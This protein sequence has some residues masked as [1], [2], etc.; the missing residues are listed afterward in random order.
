MAAARSSREPRAESPRSAGAD[1]WAQTRQPLVCLAFLAPL[2]AVYEVGVLW[3]GGP[4]PGS[5]RNG[6]DYWMRGWLHG[7][8]FTQSLLLPVLVVGGLLAWHLAGRYP[9]RVSLD[10]LAGM[11]AE[12][13]LFAFA[14]IVL[15][16]LQGIAF[17]KFGAETLLAAGHAFAPYESAG[18]VLAV[19]HPVAARAVSLVGA[20]IYEEV[21][22]RLCLLP[23]IYGLFRLSRVSPGWSALLA[24]LASSLAFAL[25]HH[26]GGERLELFAFTFRTLAGLFFAALFVLRG[27]GVTVGCH[28]AYDLIVGVLM[29]GAR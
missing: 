22:F 15:G 25:A 26:V 21:L 8:G 20:G 11:F 4:D 13:L 18:A 19:D 16:Q 5:I 7:L 14:L 29:P 1:Y 28:A 12:S 27:F 3:L 10:T 9:W 23:A 17:Q 24:V 2:L 6:A